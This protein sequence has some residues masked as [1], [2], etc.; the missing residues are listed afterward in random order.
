MPLLFLLSIWGTV[1]AFRPNGPGQARL[2][3]IALLGGAAGAGGVLLWGYISERY[4]ADF[5]PFLILAAGLGLVDLWR[6]MDGRSHRARRN[7]CGGT[8]V[9]AAYCIA[10]NLA[11]AVF[12]VAQ[13]N[14]TQTASFVSFAERGSLTSLA[15]TVQKGDSLPYWAPAGTLFAVGDCTGLYLSTGN[16][17]KD[18]PGQQIQ[19]YTWIPVEQS[20]DFTRLIGFTFNRSENDLAGPVT[21]LTYGASSLVLEPH[22][23]GHVR[24]VVDDSG[25]SIAW[26]PATGWVIPIK[27]LNTQYQV[28]ATIDPNL[29]SISV[30]W[31]GSKMIGHYVAGHAT[32]VVQATPTTPGAQPVVTVADVPLAPTPMTLCQG[33]AQGR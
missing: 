26:P 13:W 20:P 8:V 5:M 6:R 2:A 23:P 32:P 15:A 4:M 33:L 21:L 9:V 7:L 22:G 14:V 18:V 17:S 12:P 27:Y 1:T 24:L 16:T 11:I 29:D 19:H 30:T 31:Y 3:R 10:A 28:T 25:T